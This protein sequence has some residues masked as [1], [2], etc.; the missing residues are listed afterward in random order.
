MA[1][2]ADN[3]KLI[4]EL[5]EEIASLKQKQIR[6]QQIF[7]D[8]QSESADL[9]SSIINDLKDHLGVKSRISTEDQNLLKLNKEI[10]NQ[11]LNQK[12][13]ANDIKGLKKQIQQNEEKILK[14]NTA[15][16]SLHKKMT[17]SDGNRLKFIKGRFTALNKA[18]DIVEKENAKRLAGQAYD[19]KALEDAKD[20]AAAMEQQLNTAQNNLTQSAKSFILTKAQREELERVNAATKLRLEKEE[21]I[22]SVM[23]VSGTILGMMSKLFKDI[24]GSSKVFGEA[25]EKAKEEI[26]EISDD[27]GKVPSKLRGSII[28]AKNLGKALANAFTSPMAIFSFLLSQM[29]KLDK[30]IV[31]MQRSMNMTKDEAAAFNQEL[32]DAA[33]NSDTSYM[34]VQKMQKAMGALNE[35]TGIMNTRSKETYDTFARLTEGMGLSAQEAGKLEMMTK[36][37]GENFEKGALNAALT[38]VN[39]ARQNGLNIKGAKLMSEIAKTTGQVRANLG[40]NPEAIGRAVVQARLL[41]TTL[42][43]VAKIG[44]SLLNFEQSI[45]NE[46]EAELLIGRELNLERARA[47]ALTGSQE[48]LAEE[49]VDQ[50]GSLAEFSEMNVIQQN[51]LASALGMSSDEMAEMLL[52]QE[53]QNATAQELRELG[54]EDLATK[55]EQRDLTQQMGDLVERLNTL[56]MQLATGPLASVAKM[57]ATILQSTTAVWTI[58]GLIGVVIASKV[59]TSFV[60]LI[61]HVRTLKKLQIGAAIAKAWEAAM[62]AGPLSFFGGLAL[63]AV[64]T[65]AIIGAVSAYGDDLF[66]PGT[67]KSGY[68]SRVLFGPEGAI[69]LNN[70]DTV[71]AG[72][73]LFEKGDDVISTGAGNIKM[74]SPLSAT[75]IA[76]AVVTGVEKVTVQA[77]SQPSSVFGEMHSLSQVSMGGSIP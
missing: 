46:M 34:S 56:F 76:A 21:K 7:N 67:G 48:E 51:K 11:I 25:L 64:S 41:G 57:M 68:G 54:Y 77:Q 49:L 5:E 9:S 65:A 61:K 47:L 22:E 63:G 75:D 6:D 39:L 14:A 18:L 4:R 42:E 3:L 17:T 13:G 55:M 38:G 69:A 45:S 8:L 10:N 27:T 70:K 16:A 40:N 31:D 20:K 19:K 58:V 62:S 35:A 59:I 26:R 33:A 29:L 1:D 37:T 12:Y 73:K 66:S 74:D 36:A 60:N 23:G 15:E 24:P 28:A 50:V 53:Y 52:Q 32:A 43:G 44:Q 72:T 71:I 2:N 30:V